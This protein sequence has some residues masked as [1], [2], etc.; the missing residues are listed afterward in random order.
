LRT[1]W[2]NEG[3]VGGVFRGGS[4]LSMQGDDLSGSV[5]L[6]DG[7]TLLDIEEGL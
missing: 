3:K 2:V 6:V 7:A 5:E 1:Y 4:T